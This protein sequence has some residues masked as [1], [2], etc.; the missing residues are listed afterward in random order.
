MRDEDSSDGS[1][2]RQ[3]AGRGVHLRRVVGGTL[4]LR[5]GFALFAAGLH[6]G[7]GCTFVELM[8][9]LSLFAA[10]SLFVLQAFI[11]GMAHAGRSNENAAA[12][13]LA[14]QIMEQIRASVNPYAM[15]G[16]TDMPRAPLPLP[17]PPP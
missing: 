10:V 14:I 4:A 17:A 16:F 11:G 6:R 12:T 8:E 2:A 15:V 9:A 1:T 7:G 5:P 13:T 3:A